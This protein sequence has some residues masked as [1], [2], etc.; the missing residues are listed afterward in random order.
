[1]GHFLRHLRRLSIPSMQTLYSCTPGYG[2]VGTDLENGLEEPTSTD[3]RGVGFGTGEL[4]AKKNDDVTGA[5]IKEQRRK[6]S[7]LNISVPILHM[8]FNEGDTKPAFAPFKREI[9]GAAPRD[10]D[11]GWSHEVEVLLTVYWLAC[12]ASYRQSAEVFHIP[13]S[14]VCRVVHKILSKMESIIHQVIHFPSGEEMEG[15][16][17][18]FAR[19]A[20]HAVFEHA[21]GAIDDCHVR[22]VPPGEPQK[23]LHVNRKLFP[24][25]F[26][27]GSVMHK[28]QDRSER[29]AAARSRSSSLSLASRLAI[30]CLLESSF[31]S[32]AGPSQQGAFWN[33]HYVRDQGCVSDHPPVEAEAF[34]ATITGGVMACCSC[35]IE[36]MLSYHGQRAAVRNACWVLYPSRVRTSLLRCIPGKRGRSSSHPAI[37]SGVAEKRTLNWNRTCYVE[38]DVVNVCTNGDVPLEVITASSPCSATCGLGMKSQTLCLLKDGKAAMEENVQGTAAPKVTEQCRVRKVQCLDSWQCGLKTLTVTVGQRLNIDCV[39][40]VMKEMGPYSWRV[41]WRYARGIITSDDSLFARWRRLSWTMFCWTLLKR[42]TQVRDQTYRCDVQDADFRRVKRIYWGVRVLPPDVINLD[43]RRSGISKC[44]RADYNETDK[45][46]PDVQLPAAQNQRESER[47][48]VRQRRKGGREKRE[49]ERESQ[50]RKKGDG[51][52]EG[53]KEAREGEERENQREREL[54]QKRKR[55]ERKKVGR[56]MEKG[57]RG[58]ES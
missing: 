20:G 22:I 26:C 16:G 14:T 6:Y 45:P 4:A 41:S 15:I 7:Q 37:S 42:N 50:R 17:A 30:S 24:P 13:L 46:D 12:G 21:A 44:E 39:E 33:L 34:A 1:M 32:P 51:K 49:I 56:S 23:G 5:R 9:T 54:E 53:E 2:L 29:S 38:S 40:E 27:R 10:K 18:G 47:E 11:H 25:S 58:R 57:E 52:K 31:K 8:Y 48:R 36:C 19:L 35:K 3:F 28:S 43:T 55:R